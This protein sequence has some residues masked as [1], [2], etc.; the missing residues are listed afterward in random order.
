MAV[1][2]GQAARGT[3][4]YFNNTTSLDGR[5]YTLMGNATAVCG[6][7]ER[8]EH[9]ARAQAC[10]HGCGNQG[11]RAAAD[12]GRLRGRAVASGGRPRL[13]TS[14]RALYHYD[15][16]RDA[17]LTDLLADVHE[18]FVTAL[19]RVAERYADRSARERL[20][21]VNLA[22][23]KW[24]RQHRERFLLIYGDPVPGFAATHSGPTVAPAKRLGVLFGHLLFDDWPEPPGVEDHYSPRL[25]A[26]LA[27]ARAQL[28]RWLCPARYE[29]LMQAWSRLH[30]PGAAGAARAPALAATG[31]RG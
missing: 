11:G 2:V 4:S 26:T 31:G 28:T 23:R 15:P 25:A 6:L 18:D 3:M 27:T 24:T 7:A 21:E 30:G 16:S 12:G 10:R 29:Y 14:V 22:Y 20:L 1:I 8:S 17:L 13:G 19:E 9:P 5:L